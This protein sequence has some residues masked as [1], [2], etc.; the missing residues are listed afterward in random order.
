MT[1]EHREAYVGR[2]ADI[3]HQVLQAVEDGIADGDFSLDHPRDAVRAMLGMIQA[4]AA[5]FR[6][7]GEMSVDVLTARYLSLSRRLIGGRSSLT[8]FNF[9]STHMFAQLSER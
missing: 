1:P 2:R 7:D 5:W 9:C 3:E 8:P 4:I 6:P